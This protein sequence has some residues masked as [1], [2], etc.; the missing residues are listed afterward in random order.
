MKRTIPVLREVTEANSIL[1]S[2]LRDL[3]ARQGILALNLIASPGAGKTSLLERT[4]EGLHG[5]PS[6]GSGQPVMSGAAPRPLKRLVVTTSVVRRRQE[7]LKSPLQTEPFSGLP[8]RLAVIEGDPATTLDAERIAA[9]GVP[10]VQINTDGGCHLEARMI[11]QALSQIAMEQADVVVIENVGNLL[12]P[13]G[14]DLGED[15]K[16]VIASLP[17]G[18][19]KPLKYPMAF[20]TAQAVVI[21]KIDL[22]PY[23]PASVAE[24]RENVLAVNP[25]LA[26]FEVSCV[27][28]QGINH[29]IGW[30][31][32]RL[33]EKRAVSRG[34]AG[35][36]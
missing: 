29:W 16:V 25:T 26:V 3:F 34:R 9:T 20:L 33:A 5:A 4:I 13:T 18:A 14:W 22:E 2:A 1:A 6:P 15:A 17:E 27:T 11:Q 23:L 19:D 10:V 30:I 35:G 28:G 36:A 31:R 8:L 12:C 32:E 24:L 21:N 7:R